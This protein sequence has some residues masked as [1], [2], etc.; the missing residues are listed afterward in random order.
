VGPLAY[1]E[2]QWIV[3]QLSSQ[4]PYRMLW[5]SDWA[6]STTPGWQ[7]LSV[8]DTL[9]SLESQLYCGAWALCFFKHDPGTSITG[10]Q[11]TAPTK[12]H[13]AH[14]TLNMLGPVR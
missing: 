5:L 10:I 7:Q 8:G 2:R 1:Q 6:N 4:W 9:T 14:D 11:P 3:D 12:G 13:S